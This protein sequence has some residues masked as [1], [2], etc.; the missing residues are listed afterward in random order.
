MAGQ[1]A[2]KAGRI[3]HP[4]PS[5]SSDNWRKAI[6]LFAQEGRRGGVMRGGWDTLSALQFDWWRWWVH[7]VLLTCWLLMKIHHSMEWRMK[8]KM[9]VTIGSHD[10]PFSTSTLNCPLR[11]Q[12]SSF[13]SMVL[14]KLS[15]QLDGIIKS[16]TNGLGRRTDTRRAWAS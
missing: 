7:W 1:I 5:E 4:N 3:F 10:K 2:K 8:K 15:I 16:M 11:V 6:C 13:D 12:D 9:Y 14:M